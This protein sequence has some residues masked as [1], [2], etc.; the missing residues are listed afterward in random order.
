MLKN[1]YKLT[2]FALPISM[3]FLINMI[4]SFVAIFMVAK[5]GKQEL[6]A[7]ALAISSNI[8]VMTIVTTLFYALGIL[9]SHYK[10]QGK[11]VIEIGDLVKNGFWL[12]VALAIPASCLLWNLDKVLL[13]F[14][15]DQDLIVLTK[16]YFHYAAL[17]LWPTIILT[18]ITQFYSGNGYPRFSMIS[19]VICLPITIFLSYIFILGKFGLP[20]LALGG[21]TCS[22]FIV[23]SIYCIGVLF[24]MFFRKEIQKYKIFSGT[25]LPN[26]LICKN[27]FLLGYPIGLQFG[28]EIAAMTVSTYFMGFFGVIALASSQIVSQYSMLVVMTT[29]GLSQG[30]SILISEAHSRN[31]SELIKQYIFSAII[32]LSAF[33]ILVLTLFSLAPKYLLTA[34]INV[35]DPNNE[36]LIHLAISFFIISGITLFI[37][38]IRNLLSG[39]LRGLHDSKAPMNVGI[40]C[41]WIISLP[42]SYL[43]AFHLNGG[44]IGLRLGFM[45]GFIIA[46][47]LLWIRI[48]NKIN[49]I[50]FEKKLAPQSVVPHEGNIVA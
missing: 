44:P 9:I 31:D 48:K 47:F 32:I 15:Q 14:K 40:F 13:L 11:T 26:K 24:Y 6:A 10:G 38:G 46:A 19:S 17:S 4:I 43:V 22:T 3:A 37:D 50:I 20:Q 23:Q 21:I 49:F 42:L 35:N 41:L 45:S 12:A 29:L 5:L 33:F 25:L 28:G 30:L 2:S 36:H 18:V 8:T 1:I 27:I 7:G 16:E 39:G 34:F